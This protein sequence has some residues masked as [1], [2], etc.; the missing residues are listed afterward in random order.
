[1]PRGGVG[2]KTLSYIPRPLVAFLERP[3]TCLRLAPVKVLLVV[4]AATRRVKASCRARLA[5][6][7]AMATASAS[8]VDQ[9]ANR[10]VGHPLLGVVE[11]ETLGFGGVGA[12]LCTWARWDALC[13]GLWRSG[14]RKRAASRRSRGRN[15]RR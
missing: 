10:L 11:V 14:L 5:T 2:S 6:W 12:P 8:Q 9:Q 1:M 15:S 4:A 3:P 7:A 13:A